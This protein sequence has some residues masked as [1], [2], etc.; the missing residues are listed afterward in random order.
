[1]SVTLNPSIDRARGTLPQGLQRLIK[2]VHTLAWALLQPQR[3]I[4]EVETMRDL[5]DRA[6]RV[7][8]IDPAAAARLRALAARIGLD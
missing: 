6:T 2:E 1:V 8:S 3:V 7:E 5:W 4:A